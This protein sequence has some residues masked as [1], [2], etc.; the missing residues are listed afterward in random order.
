MQSVV[1][2][3]IP[4]SL[5][6]VFEV[7]QAVFEFVRVGALGRGGGSPLHLACARDS[8]SVGRYPI[9]VFPSVPAIS[10]L[11]ECGADPNSKDVEGNTALHTAALNKPAKPAVI[12]T[13]LDHGAHF[14][15]VNG[16]QKAFFHLLNKQPLHEVSNKTKEKISRLLTFNKLKKC[17]K[18]LKH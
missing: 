14:D 3:I 17:R 16:D 12:Q 2:E 10:L 5:L 11:L 15:S 13:L 4:S 7:K 6:Q 18:I 9:C 8:S 1:Y